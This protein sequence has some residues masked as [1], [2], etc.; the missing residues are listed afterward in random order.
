MLL[1]PVC[2]GF[3]EGRYAKIGNEEGAYF[4]NYYI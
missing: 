4:N 2:C 1:A 3:R